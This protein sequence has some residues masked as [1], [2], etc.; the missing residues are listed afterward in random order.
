MSSSPSSSL[1]LSSSKIDRLVI[2][3]QEIFA[4]TDF[5]NAVREVIH[6][7]INFGK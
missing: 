5:V 6:S 1:L 7:D 2:I 4:Q 3:D